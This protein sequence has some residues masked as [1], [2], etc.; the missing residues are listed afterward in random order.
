MS[1]GGYS[2]GLLSQNSCK[3]TPGD[4]SEVYYIN[5]A[6]IVQSGFSSNGN[7]FP[8][9]VIPGLPRNPISF[10]EDKGIPGQAWDDKGA[11]LVK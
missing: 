9:F 2:R 6:G 1:L 11:E 4:N 3:T 8:F 5:F 10:G 7:Q